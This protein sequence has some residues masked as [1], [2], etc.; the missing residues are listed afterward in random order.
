MY[1]AL[2][3]DLSSPSVISFKIKI[4]FAADGNKIHLPIVEVLLRAVASDLAISK[5]QRDWNLCNSV[6]LPPFLT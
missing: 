5:K 1:F 2:A 6:L 4:A 3:G